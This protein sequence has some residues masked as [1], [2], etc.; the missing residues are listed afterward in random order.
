[1]DYVSQIPPEKYPYLNGLTHQVME[2]RY[3]G[4]H[5]FEFGLELI[6]EGLDKVRDII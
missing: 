1:K 3:D 6:L 4:L 5:D 2:G